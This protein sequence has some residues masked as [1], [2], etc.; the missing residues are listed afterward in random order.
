MNIMLVSVVERRREI[1]IRMA[2]GAGQPDILMMFLIESIILTVFGGLVGIIV[3]VLVSFG[4]AEA[5]HWGFQ[6]FVPPIMLGFTVSVIVGILSGFYPALRASRLD[7]IQC[8]AD[9]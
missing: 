2:I 4:V 7:P 3:G 1:G 6:L 9:E 5:S 8:L